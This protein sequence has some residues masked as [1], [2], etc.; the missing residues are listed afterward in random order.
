MLPPIQPPPDTRWVKRV[1]IQSKMLTEWWGH[2]VYLGAT[3][4]LPKGWDENPSAAVSDDL[5]P[6]PLRRGRAR[7]AS[8]LTASPRR[9][10]RWRARLKRTS[11]EPGYEFSQAWMGE[12]FPR[13]VAISFQH[14]TPWYDDSYAMNSVNQGPY[15][16]AL[17]TELIPYLEEKFHLVPEG[18]R[19]IPHRRF[20]RRMG[21]ARA[22]DPSPGFLRRAPGRCIPTAS[23]SR[24]T[25]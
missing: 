1:K 5:H 19:A 18:K 14:P 20:D 3:V 23:I 2:P 8:I 10:P 6:G 24:A 7:S 4:L 16:D 13:M 22:P 17:L 11:R 12:D 25:R 21:S 15:G 9:R